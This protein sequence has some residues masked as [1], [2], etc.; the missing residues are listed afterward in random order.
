MTRLAQ[1]S[2]VMRGP[3]DIDM[4]EP[5]QPMLRGTRPRFRWV[6]VPGAAAYSFR[7]RQAGGPIL[8]EATT[9]AAAITLAGDLQLQPGVKYQWTL[10][11]NLPGVRPLHSEGEFEVLDPARSQAL[12]RLRV[13]AARGFSQRLIY[14]S[15]LQVIG[16]LDEAK[17]EWRALAR[18]R[19][20]DP[21]L[22]GFAR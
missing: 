13:A 11:T 21:M 3:Q 20:D 22:Q 16:L 2:L 8:Q 7:L 9:Q 1:A 10:S 4:A 19:P 6:P 17:V 5:S 14:A 18:Q 12:D 15:T